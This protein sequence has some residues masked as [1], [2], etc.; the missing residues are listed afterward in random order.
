MKKKDY[1]KMFKATLSVVFDSKIDVQTKLDVIKSFVSTI[2]YELNE[3][4][5][6][7]TIKHD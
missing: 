2:A 4:L 5:K 7:E 6:E 3:E 1:K